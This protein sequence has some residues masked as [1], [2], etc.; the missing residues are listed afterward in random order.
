MPLGAKKIVISGGPGTGKTSIVKVLES[1]GYLCFHEVIRAMTLEARKDTDPAQLVTNPLAFVPD[2]YDFNRRILESRLDHY[3]DGTRVANEV[4]FFDRGLPDVLAYMDYFRQAYSDE[5][6]AI[7]TS[8][9][10]DKVLLLPPWE[11]IYVSDN[12]RLECFEE[13]LQI[14][15]YITAAYE[16]FG[17]TPVT[18]PEGSIRERTTF[19]L[20][21]LRGERYL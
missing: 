10:Y 16:R 8:N 1:M 3:R 12:E 17:Y 6:D 5:F 19:I 9:R 20:D 18:V 11:D 4:V 13:A 7:C 2:P 21:H 14:H 15:Q